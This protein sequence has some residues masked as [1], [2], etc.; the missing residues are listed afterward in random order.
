[1]EEDAG[2]FADVV[3]AEGAP[4]NLLR[5]A[6]AEGLDVLPVEDNGTLGNAMDDVVLTSEMAEDDRS[7]GSTRWKRQND[8]LRAET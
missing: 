4:S 3:R 6:A 7:S 1:M 5:I 8:P 2:G